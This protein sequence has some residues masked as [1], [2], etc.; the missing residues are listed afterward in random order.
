MSVRKGEKERGKGLLFM[1]QESPVDHET[2]TLF[3]K[4][5]RERERGRNL[6]VH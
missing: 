4:R 5:E 3:F 1:D 6:K 2:I